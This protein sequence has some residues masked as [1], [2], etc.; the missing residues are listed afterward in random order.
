MTQNTVKEIYHIHYKATFNNLCKSFIPIV[1]MYANAKYFTEFFSVPLA[2]FL[3][4]PA[5][6]GAYKG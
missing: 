5:V 6:N 2:T 1:S 4:C 3:R